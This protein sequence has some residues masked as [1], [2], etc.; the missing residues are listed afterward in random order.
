L[1]A[2]SKSP[3]IREI[4]NY[5]EVAAEKDLAARSSVRDFED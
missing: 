1:S 3:D 4:T 2:L 5:G